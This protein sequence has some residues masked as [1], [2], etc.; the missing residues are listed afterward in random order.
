MKFKKHK[1]L[2]RKPQD[3]TIEWA[4][5]VVAQHDCDAIVSHVQLMNVDIGTTTRIHLK[6]DIDGAAHLPRSWFIKLPSLSWRARAITAL[7]RL[8]HTE[9]RFYKELAPNVPLKKPHCLAAHSQLGHGSTLVLADIA[10]NAHIPSKPDYAL[11]RQQ[12]AVIIE[13]LANFHAHFSQDIHQP[14]YQWLKGSI[15]QLEDTLGSA[16]ALPLMQRGLKLAGSN[17]PKS[18]HTVALRYAKHRRN[19]MNYLYQAPHT[20]VHHDC[21]PGNLFWNNDQSQAGFLDWQLVRTGEGVSDIAYILANGLN[22]DTRKQ[23]EFQLLADYQ[24]HMNAKGIMLN[25]EQLRQRYR[26]HLTYA[27]EAMVV[28]LAVGGLMNLEH[29]RELI[30]R[31][32]TAVHDL[33][34]F[35]A[36]PW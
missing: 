27:F 6:V 24:Q 8:L 33:D 28:T 19:I 25:S 18:L 7:P 31:T 13:Q 4:Q 26:A 10:E 20:L 35:S 1:L 3:L 14:H 23:Y 30:R 17:V 5:N 29:N 12:A 34:A 36:L 2:A 11:N 32:A 16:L 22:P 21:H 15:R 9:V